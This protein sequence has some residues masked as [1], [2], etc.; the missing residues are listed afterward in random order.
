MMRL[1]RRNHLRSALLGPR[2]LWVTTV[3]SG[4]HSAWFGRLFLWCAWIW[5]AMIA[6]PGASSFANALAGV[7]T[8]IGL[9]GLVAF[10]PWGSWR[11]T[12]G[13][14]VLALPFTVWWCGYVAVAGGGPG[15]EP[16]VAALRTDAGE[17]SGAI[18]LAITRP[19]LM[20]AAVGHVAFLALACH[21]AW[22]APSVA[23]AQMDR[24]VLGA[25]CL[26][27]L[28]VVVAIAFAEQ[29][30]NSGRHRPKRPPGN[31][32]HT[33]Q[34]LP[35][36]HA[37]FGPATFMSPLGSAEEIVSM[38]YR[39]RL[40][41]EEQGYRRRPAT[42][43]IRVTD[44]TLAI[45]YLGESARAD[46]FGPSRRDRGVASRQLYERIASG[47]G[48]W[49]PPTCA[50]SD[51]THLSVPMLLTETTPSHFQDAATTP[52][53]LGELHAAGFA[54]AWLA[55]NQAGPT[56]T[57]RGHDMYAGLF[58]VNPDDLYGEKFESWTVDADMVP[59]ARDF[60]LR[61]PGPSAILMHSIGS[62]FPYDAR[63]PKDFF[64]AEPKDLNGDELLEL[65]YER[66]LEFT[67]RAILDVTELLDRNSS[68]AF[69][70]YTSD[71]GENLPSDQNGLRGHLGARTSRAVALVPS[72]IL[73]NTAMAR[74]GRPAE[75]LSHV[76]TRPMIAHVDISRIFLAMAGL[77]V[78]TV[79]PTTEPRIWGRRAVG[80]PYADVACSALE[81]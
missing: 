41:A 60:I 7:A 44:P 18:T 35:Q 43:A 21:R 16:A 25:L 28:M 27:A 39:A 48:T 20:W 61:R 9:A 29:L 3:G 57:E 26:S 80:E 45:F 68:P 78:G 63:Y 59:V 34:P 2:G 76:S 79:E 73:W 13:L 70:V 12:C 17:L 15:Y 8:A 42:S 31:T 30:T 47:L 77:T 32:P 4:P 62:H 1:S 64:A 46:G 53:V 5:P 51:G 10:A 50:S 67:A 49:L 11:T 66:S 6:V 65:R 23:S 75:V 81:P 54:T 22:T 56:A 14:S 19:T 36:P 38:N 69:L 40:H 33:Y 55:N 74:T 72:F 71:H 52:T 58:N 37:L 24:R